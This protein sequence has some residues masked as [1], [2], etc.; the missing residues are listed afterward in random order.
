MV[1]PLEVQL[2]ENVDEV[3]DGAIVEALGEWGRQQLPSGGAALVTGGRCRY[4]VR[5]SWRGG[6]GPEEVADAVSSLGPLV[7]RVQFVRL[8]AA[9]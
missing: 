2:P 6:P 1:T 7:E 4:M 9:T 3:A 8:P 5:L